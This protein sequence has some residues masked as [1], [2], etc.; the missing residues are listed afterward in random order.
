MCPVIDN[1]ASCKISAVIHLLHAKSMNAAEIHHELCAVYSQ[2]HY[3][4]VSTTVA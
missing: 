2:N 3:W 4:R 1:L